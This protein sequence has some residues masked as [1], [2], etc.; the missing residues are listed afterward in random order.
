MEPGKLLIAEKMLRWL[1]LR[2]IVER[3]DVEMGLRRQL[4]HSQVRVEPQV[5]QKPRVVP[6]EDLNFVISPLVTV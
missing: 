6:G 1:E 2:R 5:R 3:A 4:H